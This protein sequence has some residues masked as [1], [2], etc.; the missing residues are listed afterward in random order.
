[1]GGGRWEVAGETPMKISKKTTRKR[2]YDR[3]ANKNK[4]TNKKKD[5]SNLKLSKARGVLSQF[6]WNEDE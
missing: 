1:M 2:N 4:Q 3:G 5:A 6:E